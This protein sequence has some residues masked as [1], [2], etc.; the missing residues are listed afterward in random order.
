MIRH[1]Q[2]ILVYI[3]TIL[4]ISFFSMTA[5]DDHGVEASPLDIVIVLCSDCSGRGNCNF[6]TIQ[7]SETE[8]FKRVSCD[9]RTGYTGF[10]CSF[11]FRTPVKKMYFMFFHKYKKRLF[12]LTL[13]FLVI[14][15]FFS[16]YKVKTVNVR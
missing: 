11:F 1:N 10:L 2:C 6:T 7:I 14:R 15:R 8:Q 9:C 5:I 13:I 3:F 12:H 16:Y 4:F